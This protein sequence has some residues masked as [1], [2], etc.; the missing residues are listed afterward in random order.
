MSSLALR[1]DYAPG[2]DFRLRVDCELPADGVTAIYGASGSGKSTLLDC[3]AGLRRPADNGLI[4]LGEE[5][6]SKGAEQ[7]P[8]W[9]RGAG[10]VFNEGHLFPHL[11]VLGNL[12]YAQKRSRRA[13]FDLD[14][15]ATWLE[16]SDL[17]AR[18]PQTLSAGQR[19]RVAIARALMSSPR[20]LLLDEPFANL[21]ALATRH[22][23]GLLQRLSRETDLPMLFVSHDIEEVSELADYLVLLDSGR[24][25]T[26]GPLLELCGRLDNRLAREEKAAAIVQGTIA[27]HDG[28]YGLTELAVEDEL[29]VVPSIAQDIG[30]T[31]RLR[32]PARDVSICLQ[33]P[34]DSSILNIIPVQI[35]QIDG[36]TDARVMLRLALGSQHLLARL[37]RRSADALR[38]KV[39]DRVFAQV[40]TAALLSTRADGP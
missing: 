8:A 14:A 1:I 39:G 32:I 28:E 16:I 2:N 23:L 6:W 40:K 27:R 21:D 4:R 12:R 35:A 36:G 19:Q 38:L 20:L 18:R 10:Y 33:R 3:I 9:Q 30:S 31:Q 15:V 5:T 11:S 26:H 22:C 37:T 17:L 34:G 7:L 13:A 29:M 25:D 24:V